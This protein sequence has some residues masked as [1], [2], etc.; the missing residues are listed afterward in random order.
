[1][2]IPVELHVFDIVRRI[3]VADME[4][5]SEL[6][7]FLRWQREVGGGGRKLVS[8]VMDCHRHK[9]KLNVNGGSFVWVT[10]FDGEGYGGIERCMS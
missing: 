3:F 8:L 7:L 5:G 2:S 9:M 6:G 4:V 10:A 1:M